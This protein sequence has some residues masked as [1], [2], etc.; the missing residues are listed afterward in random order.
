MPAA[1]EAP[2]TTTKVVLVYPTEESASYLNY[3]PA[4]GKDAP[5]WHEVLAQ[6]KRR[7][8]WLAPQHPLG[9]ASRWTRGVGTDRRNTLTDAHFARTPR[10][11]V[12]ST[13]ARR[14]NSPRTP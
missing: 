1:R 6:S 12:Q 2:T 11:C 9:G 14:T 4:L 10:T 7:M 5:K 13:C 8:E 3:P